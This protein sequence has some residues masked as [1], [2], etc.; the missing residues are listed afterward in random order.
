[1]ADFDEKIRE[2]LEN[3][4]TF[5]G[6][7]DQLKKAATETVRIRVQDPCPKFG[8]GCNCQ[9]IRFIE[10][11]AYETKLKLIQWLADRGVGRAA[12]AEG[13]SGERIIFERIVY[14]SDPED[15][16]ADAA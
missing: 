10:V 16:I 8:K 14:L 4:E 6:I 1:M 13:E 5:L 11:P 7:I 3:D 2:A 12:V 15:A 9:H